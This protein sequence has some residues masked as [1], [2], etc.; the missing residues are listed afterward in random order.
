[1][2]KRTSLLPTQTQDLQEFIEN[3]ENTA[4]DMKAAQAVL[5]INEGQN[6]AFIKRYTG[7]SRSRAHQLATDFLNGGIDAIKDKRKGPP[8]NLLTSE[9]RK[10]LIQIIK[11]GPRKYGYGCDFWSSGMLS[12]YIL[13]HFNV[14][15]KSKKPIYILFKDAEFSY[16]LP[17]KIYRNRNQEMIDKWTVETEP[18]LQQAFDEPD[19]IVL[20]EDEMILTSTT[21]TQKVWIPVNQY[22]KIEVANK[23]ERRS[24]YGFI[25]I[26]TGSIHA[27]KTEYQ[28]MFQTVDILKRIREL[29]PSKKILLLWDNAGWHKGSEV[30]KFVEED[31]N[32]KTHNFPPYAP[33]LNP[34]E[35]VWKLGRSAVTH[36]I[37]IEKI[38]IAADKFVDFLNNT[39][40]NYHLLGYGPNF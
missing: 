22:P 17:G 7:F 12:D 5:M 39:K 33:E 38:D 36:N 14:R 34:Q 24:F 8:K 9:Q 26:K 27:F 16:H 19:T 20:C 21:T 11:D 3:S 1:M 10:E 13:R 2:K 28:N 18:I 4:R 31:G 29:Y 23:R 6:H 15:Y 37:F 40:C 25:N 30:V 35:H 32:I